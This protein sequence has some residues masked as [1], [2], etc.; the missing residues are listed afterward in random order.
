[1][2]EELGHELV[3]RDP[4]YGLGASL[5]FVQTWM[6]GIYEEARGLP[7][8]STLERSSRQLAAAGRIIVPDRRRERIRTQRTGVS[9]RIL[10][11]WNE[12][13]VLLT[14]AL[15][16]T[17]I[18]AEGGY[19]RAAPIALER[20]A[21][22]MPYSPAFNLTGQPAVTVPAGFGTGG[23][24]LSVQLVGRMGAEDV[25]YALAAQIEA[26]RPWTQHRPAIA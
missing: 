1:L 26:A 4:D 23:L 6:R 16:T 5:L 17:A 2:L 19:G 18:A 22:F 24:P 11:L 7:Q 8:P 13:D 3:E 9:N 12:V 20:A 15:A 25:L 14:P 21:R 10:A